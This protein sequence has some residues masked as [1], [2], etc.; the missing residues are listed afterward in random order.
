[1]GRLFIN[2]P[3]LIYVYVVS[4]DVPKT[5]FVKEKFTQKWKFS[6]YM[7][8]CH[9]P[10]NISGVS[11]W[12]TEAHG[13]LFKCEKKK[14][15]WVDPYSLSSII[16]SKFWNLF[17]NMFC[18]TTVDSVHANT[19]SSAATVK[20]SALKRLQKRW[21]CPLMFLFNSK[22]KRVGKQPVGYSCGIF[23]SY[24]SKDGN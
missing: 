3:W 8:S 20:I 16:Q 22:G 24:M 19:Y 15:L 5:I 2:P 7:H 23:I 12:T 18:A 14:K 6:H 21:T 1:M 4:E 11:S 17:E 13:D 10:Q 9:S